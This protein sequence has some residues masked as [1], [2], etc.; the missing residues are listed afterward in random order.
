MESYLKSE[1]APIFFMVYMFVTFYYFNNVV[2]AI[3]YIGLF[4]RNYNNNNI[5]AAGCCF[6]QIQEE[7]QE[8]ITTQTV[9]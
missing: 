2:S 7:V 9:N 3:V 5:I 1:F 6:C 8:N 4:A